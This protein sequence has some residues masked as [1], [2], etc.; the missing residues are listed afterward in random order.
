M[1]V[2]LLIALCKLSPDRKPTEEDTESEVFRDE[3][4]VTSG[5]AAA[6]IVVDSA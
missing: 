5:G 6:G 2:M 3:S 4:W 1:S